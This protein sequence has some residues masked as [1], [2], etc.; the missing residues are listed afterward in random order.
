M[1]VD[2]KNKIDQLIINSPFEEPQLYWKF[3]EVEGGFRVKDG[4]REAGY[5]IASQSKKYDEQG[6]TIPLPLV[7]K[8]RPRIK[9]WREGDYQG[10]TGITKRLLKFW[11][12][13]RA[14]GRD[15]EFFFCQLEAIETL[16]WLKEAYDNERNGIVIPKDGGAFER[17]CCKMATGTGKTYVMAMTIAWQIL[18]KVTYP[19]NASFSKNI[20]I[21]APNLTVKN[22]LDVL[23]PNKAGNYYEQNKIVPYDL[24]PKLR[25]GRVIVNN[26]HALMDDTKKVSKQKTVDKRGPKSNEAWVREVLGNDMARSREKILVINDEAHHAWRKNKELT[27]VDK[28][29]EKIATCWVEGLDRINKA[30][31][32]L[33]CF[34]FSATPFVLSGTKSKKSS[35]ENLFDWIVSDF[36]LMDAIESGLTKTPRF[37]VRD[38]APNYHK[39]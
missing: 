8:I 15:C 13:E 12:Q 22:R 3:D 27:D 34:D 4:R 25:Q 11:K 14:D 21:V 24:L 10:V 28:T 6:T 39:D 38:D 23:Y 36:G 32:I 16:I 35:K 37:V 7:N 20:F 33:T 30:R 5:V 26:W 18:N 2:C 31:G 9:K 1:G 19:Q 29:E 17:L